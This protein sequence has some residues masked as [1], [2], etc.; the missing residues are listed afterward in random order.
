MSAVAQLNPL[1]SWMMRML[2]AWRAARAERRHI[3]ETAAELQA[4]TDAELADL[5]LH[6]SALD[7]LA[8]DAV[9]NG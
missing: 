6:R 7:R 9:R 4:M 8:I 5:D 2:V 1:T 3:R